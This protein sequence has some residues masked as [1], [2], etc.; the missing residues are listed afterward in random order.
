MAQKTYEQYFKE[1]IEAIHS[2]TDFS[3]L[4]LLPVSI[5]H[6]ILREILETGCLS[7]NTANIL[8]AREA[9]SQVP[10]QWLYEHLPGVV[11]LCLF[12][13]QEWQEWEFRRLAEMLENRFP[14][15]FAW[16]ISYAGELNNPEVDEAVCDYS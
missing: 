11:P 3:R 10:S 7:Q 13:E 8:L 1:K 5:S 4:D 15:S 16:L 2:G 9:L 12:K 6:D 14:D